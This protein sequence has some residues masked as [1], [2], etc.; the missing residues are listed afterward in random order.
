MQLKI[1]LVFR[2]LIDNDI[3]KSGKE[4]VD[5]RSFSDDLKATVNLPMEHF[6]EG[7]EVAL[8]Y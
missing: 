3:L 4:T 1:Y 6:S 7:T 2:Q 5:I 8:C